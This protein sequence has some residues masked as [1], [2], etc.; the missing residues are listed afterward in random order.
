MFNI[1]NVNNWSISDMQ[2]FLLKHTRKLYDGKSTYTNDVDL[3]KLTDSQ[4][5]EINRLIVEYYDDHK[6][7]VIIHTKIGFV[8]NVLVLM[9]VAA[10]SDGIKLNALDFYKHS[11]YVDLATLAN[12]C[13]TV[14][15]FDNFCKYLEE[16]ATI[17][18]THNM[19][20]ILL[21]SAQ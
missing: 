13:K 11:N 17:F 4:W 3:G 16:R 10:E 14:I 15:A 19:N 7:Y 21:P 18:R 2:Q 1:E 12:Y 5:S 6:P 20:K 8:T 9:A